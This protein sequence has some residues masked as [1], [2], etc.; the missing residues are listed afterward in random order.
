MDSKCDKYRVV[1][2]NMNK[3]GLIGFIGKKTVRLNLKLWKFVK[4]E[5]QEEDFW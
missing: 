4:K 2:M 5:N 1:F 3:I